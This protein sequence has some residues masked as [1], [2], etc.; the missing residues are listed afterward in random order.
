M[1]RVKVIHGVCT[2]CHLMVFTTSKNYNLQNVLY[3]VLLASTGFYSQEARGTIL[4][5]NIEN[6]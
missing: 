2:G 6:Q 1:D 5:Q 4:L 3:I